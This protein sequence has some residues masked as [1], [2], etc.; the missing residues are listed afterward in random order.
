MS[1]CI[2][3]NCVLRSYLLQDLLST[4]QN[5]AKLIS[6]LRKKISI[7]KKP[8][9]LSKFAVRSQVFDLIKA[10]RSY[11]PKSSDYVGS[12]ENAIRGSE[13]HL[14]TNG[15]TNVRPTEDDYT[16]A[17]KTT[18]IATS[19][20]P[21][22][23]FPKFWSTGNMNSSSSKTTNDSPTELSSQSQSNYTTAVA[24]AMV[25]MDE[26]QRRRAFAHYD[27]QSLIAKLGYGGKLKSLLSKRRNTTTG[28][29][30][31]SMLS[32]RSTTPD[33]DSGEEDSGDGRSNDL[34][35]R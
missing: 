25:D 8:E 22:S 16:S 27:C 29:S 23:K 5:I 18:S 10:N 15:L 24:S 26:K 30:A 31:A 28:A 17:N 33:G 20:K 3:R 34:I 14:A 4:V 19:P 21:K 13:N 12:V 6:Q 7:C 11:D 1:N 32:G 35:E 2:L 9:C